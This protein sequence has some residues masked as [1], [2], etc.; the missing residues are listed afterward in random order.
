MPITEPIT[1]IGKL[2]EK[3]KKRRE[4]KGI[5][6]TG[7]PPP[8]ASTK[9]LIAEGVGNLTGSSKK[10]EDGK[11]E[12]EITKKPEDLEMESL[13]SSKEK[14]ANQNESASSSKSHQV[15]QGQVLEPLPSY[16]DVDKEASQA[17]SSANNSLN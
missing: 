15:D 9:K 11:K 6:G 12:E 3:G 7:I 8:I 17:K 14:E 4:E 2:H 5:F 13:Q 10:K 1:T 16:G